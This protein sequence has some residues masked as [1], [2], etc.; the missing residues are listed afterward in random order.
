MTRR[1]NFDR[2]RALVMAFAVIAGG[3][4][5]GGCDSIGEN[6]AKAIA[7]SLTNATN[8]LP[9]VIAQ[10]DTTLQD[11]IGKLGNT[12]DKTLTDT[13]QETSRAIHAQID[14]L[15]D[16]LSGTIK[17][18]DAML[19]ARIK[20]L[21]D[22]ALGFTQEL[23][24][25]LTNGLRELK[26][27]ANTLIASLGVTGEELLEQA[28][29]TVV[30]SVNEG[31]KVV[32]KILG[33]VV[34]TVVLVIAGLVF[35]L[36]LIFGGIFFI[37][38]IRKAKR[39]TFAE[40]A[41]GMGFFVLGV[42]LGGVLLFSK[43]ARASIASDTLEFDDGSASCS[44]TL[45]ETLEFRVKNGN[46]GKLVLPADPQIKT[47]C[48]GLLTGLFRCEGTCYSPDLRNKARENVAIL[49][50][51][52]GLD[53][54]CRGAA[55]CD[56]GAG[57]H[58]D[59]PSGLCLERC[60]VDAECGAPDVCHA[61]VGRCGPLCA[62]D[63]ACANPALRCDR[64]HCIAKANQ[65]PPPSTSPGRPHWK[66]RPGLIERVIQTPQFN[67]CLIG[68]TC[69]QVTDPRGAVVDPVPGA[70]VKVGSLTRPVDKIAVSPSTPGLAGPGGAQLRRILANPQLRAGT[71]SR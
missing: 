15:H 23:E 4:G 57:E 14:A 71:L 45:Q 6:A 56:R 35:G 43:T 27:T 52:L 22:F 50:S 69:Q 40:L 17:Q 24:Q 48:L 60:E 51:A 37:N 59:I 29:F 5:C 63:A 68:A 55:D 64:G 49:Q 31:G 19:A 10:M 65:P 46:A 67:V 66:F 11:V 28:G 32:L 62:N 3:K 58:C 12:L 47:Q 53:S 61:I 54:H 13:I 39:P 70:V 36:S 30:K 44:A 7:D 41:P 1:S 2:V 8:K 26:H 38:S 33:G 20:Q 9:D 25:M 42:L 18:V 16:V 34:E 21:T